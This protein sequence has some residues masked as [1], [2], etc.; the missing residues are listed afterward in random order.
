MVQNVQLYVTLRLKSNSNS[1]PQYTQ[2]LCEMIVYDTL[3]GRWDRY[4]SNH[5]KSLWSYNIIYQ[6]LVA[7][8]SNYAQLFYIVKLWTLHRNHK[9]C[10]YPIARRRALSFTQKR[11]VWN[12]NVKFHL[13]QEVETK[14]FHF[15]NVENLSH[16]NVMWER[17]HH[18]KFCLWKVATTYAHS[19]CTHHPS[20]FSKIYM[21]PLFSKFEFNVTLS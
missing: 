15:Q 6:R 4:A 19:A 9:S 20:D 18:Q 2:I 14:V 12:G 21:A 5:H 11:K 7:H 13:V 3:L 8:I 17:R 16:Q 10:K 1:I